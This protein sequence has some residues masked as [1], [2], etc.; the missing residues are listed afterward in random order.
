[1]NPFVYVMRRPVKTLLLV[2]ALVCGGVL[3]CSRMGVGNLSQLS[4]PK[5]YVYLAGI[6]TTAQA[7]ERVRRRPP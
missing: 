3:G 6:G 4:T 5:I 7:D 2:V 1:M